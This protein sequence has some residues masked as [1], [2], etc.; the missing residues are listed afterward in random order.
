V[1]EKVSRKAPAPVLTLHRPADEFPIPELED[2]RAGKAEAR[3]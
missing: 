1:T 3:P 2:E